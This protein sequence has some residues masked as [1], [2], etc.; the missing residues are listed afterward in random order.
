MCS[1]KCRKTDAG[2][3]GS[4]LPQAAVAL[5]SANF[6]YNYMRMAEDRGDKAKADVPSGLADFV[7]AIPPPKNREN[8]GKSLPRVSQCVTLCV[9]IGGGKS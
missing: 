7:S 9:A 2:A 8:K 5:W 1:E 4:A 3:G 6:Y